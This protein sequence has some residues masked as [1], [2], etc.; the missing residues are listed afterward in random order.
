MSSQVQALAAATLLGLSVALNGA[1]SREQAPLPV[2]DTSAFA[3]VPAPSDLAAELV[4][5]RPAELG[6][7]YE[8]VAGESVRLPGSFELVLATVLELPPVAAASFDLSRPI[9]GALLNRDQAEPAP[10][11]GGAGARR[12][13]SSDPRRDRTERALRVEGELGFRTHAALAEKRR[14]ERCS[15]SIAITYSSRRRPPR[16]KARRRTWCGHSGHAR[17]RR[18]R[19]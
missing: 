18:S 14:A 13:R 1:C 15:A 9:L 11:R 2:S 7:R 8:G 17:Y 6:A 5:P 12:E 3:P 16:S 10:G 4:V 19:S